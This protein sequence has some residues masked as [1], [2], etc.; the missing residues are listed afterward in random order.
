MKDLISYKNILSGFVNAHSGEIIKMSDY[1]GTHP[2]LS[3]QEF[4]SSR[5]LAEKLQA[6]GFEVEYPFLGLP[7]AFMASKK[8]K[9]YKHGDPRVA[10]MAEYDA[11]PDIGHGCGH[12]L[13]GTMATYAGIALAEAAAGVPC[14]VCVVGTPAEETD[15]AKTVMSEK[16]V[17]DD[18]DF[19]IMFHSF[20][21]ET[22]ADERALALDGYEFTFTGRT[23]HAAA[24]PWLGRSAQNGLLL[25]MD[26]INMYR[27]HMR[28]MCRVHGIITSV[29]GAS[30][31]IPDK[32]VCRIEARAPKRATLNDMMEA[33][34]LCAKGS[35]IATRTEVSYKKFMHSFDDML[36]N[37]TAEHLTEDVLAGYGIECTH[38]HEPNGSTDVGNVSYR[39]PAIQPEFSITAEALD[40]HTREMAAA[41]MSD[42]GHAS[43][44]TGT[45]AL[46]EICL[47][48]IEDAEIRQSIREEFIKRKASI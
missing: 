17:F 34:F 2:E 36:P 23:S 19:A 44:L 32:A 31:I 48:V 25:F 38:G 41:T 43:L 14:E 37:V 6:A 29:S 21:G 24:T 9:G 1:I 4:N 16:G 46:A 3:E 12:N 10:I 11:L 28:D 30:N 39:C 47:C 45:E 15:G 35:A 18:M 20:A 5:L 8:S 42:E 7:T 26:A 33:I 22:Y 40:L 13:H 27:L